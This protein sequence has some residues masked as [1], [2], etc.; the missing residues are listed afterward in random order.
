MEVIWRTHLLHPA[1]Y[2]EDCAR[3]MELCGGGSTDGCGVIDRPCLATAQRRVVETLGGGP[4]SEELIEVVVEGGVDSE[5]RAGVDLVAAVR[6]Q[7]T[8]MGK[9][10][11]WRSSLGTRAAVAD[12]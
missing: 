11:A 8:F 12:G 1:A 10:L 7:Q 3:L 6:R 9:M 2:K 4:P 5:W